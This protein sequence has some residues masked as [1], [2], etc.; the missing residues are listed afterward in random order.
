MRNPCA[1]SSSSLGIDDKLGRLTWLA[2]VMLA[3]T[4]L[5]LISQI[6]LLVAMSRLD[7]MRAIA[8]SI[9]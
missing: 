3:L 6:A 4:V 5:L 2:Y 1:G 7:Q 9:G 8:T